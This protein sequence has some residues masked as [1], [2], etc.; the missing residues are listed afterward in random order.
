[1][2]YEPTKAGVLTRE[3]FRQMLV[4]AMMAVQ[5]GTVQLSLVEDWI[6]EQREISGGMAD[7]ALQQ[8]AAQDGKL[9]LTEFVS[10]VKVEGSVQALLHELPRI[11]ES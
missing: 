3:G 10:F 4:D 9:D 8:F 6:E 1:M 11:F 5:E 2:M 7:L